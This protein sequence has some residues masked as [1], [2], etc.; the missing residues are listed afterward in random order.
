MM[1]D[2]W[3]EEETQIKLSLK[4]YKSG[5]PI[6]RNNIT[7]ILK[8]LECH[9]ISGCFSTI[10]HVHYVGAMQTSKDGEQK[11]HTFPSAG[12]RRSLVGDTLSPFQQLIL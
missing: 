7:M 2:F 8:T 3:E 9:N 12:E 6:H 1:L 5:Q 10:A 11:T 4:I